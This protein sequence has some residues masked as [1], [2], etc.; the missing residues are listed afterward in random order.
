MV[1]G[2]STTVENQAVDDKL[3]LI[4]LLLYS[5]C[6]VENPDTPPTRVMPKK[7]FCSNMVVLFVMNI[8]CMSSQLAL[9]VYKKMRE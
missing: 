4:C 8:S 6:G 5:D 2:G 7:A 3:L 9:T 1:V